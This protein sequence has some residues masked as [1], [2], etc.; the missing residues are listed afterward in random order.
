MNHDYDDTPTLSQTANEIADLKER[1]SSFD[2][3][4][5]AVVDFLKRVFPNFAYPS[6]P[7]WH[8]VRE[9]GENF[10]E[11]NCSCCRTRFPTKL[12]DYFV[13]C[14]YEAV[15]G[16]YNKEVS[17]NDFDKGGFLSGFR[18]RKTVAEKQYQ[19]WRK[20]VKLVGYSWQEDG[21]TLVRV[22]YWDDAHR[23]VYGEQGKYTVEFKPN[24]CEIFNVGVK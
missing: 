14:D 16:W 5:F 21:D 9:N 17:S 1:L 19:A 20:D 18:W 6:K 7:S 11:L 3:Y 10:V 23:A 2:H 12:V 24:S 4:V 8:V 15:K 22:F 13:S